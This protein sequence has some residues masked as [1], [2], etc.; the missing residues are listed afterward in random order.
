[1]SDEVR[2][3]QVA[4]F[5]GIPF[6]KHFLSTDILEEVV[7]FKPDPTDIFVVTYPKCGTTW[8]QF[9]V[10]EIINQ[11]APPPSPN[12]MMLSEFPFLEATGIDRLA[13]LPKPRL[14]KTH[15]PFQL[16]PYHPSAKYI[17]VMRNPWDCC[18]SY[19]HHM[20]IEFPNR[21]FSFDTFFDHFIQGKAPYGD[22]FDHVLS[23]YAHRNDSNKLFLTYE[24]MLADRKGTMLTTAKFLGEYYYEMLNS[25][26]EVLNNCLK[27]TEFKYMKD[28]GVFIPKDMHNT[29]SSSKTLE[30][31]AIKA[32]VE[33]MGSVDKKSADLE[34]FKQWD[35]F[36]KGVIGD[37]KNYFTEDHVQRFTDYIKSKTSNTD[38]MEI[39][40][41]QNTPQ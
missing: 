37:W 2:E 29:G 32:F 27:H 38:I 40:H 16:Q 34:K 14:M 25:D 5:R 26:E 22:F 21:K 15:L 19:Y 36:R 33:A 20:K 12:K 41:C 28:M 30:K 7:Q 31:D 23:W 13:Q 4:Y 6:L 39:L 35:F 24:N 1:M 11:G 18:V 8:M 3:I 9:I 17:Y 10:W